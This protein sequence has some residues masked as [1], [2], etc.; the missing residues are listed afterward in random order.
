MPKYL[1]V[2]SQDLKGLRLNMCLAD[3]HSQ[4]SR[5]T[6]PWQESALCPDQGSL[7]CG[8]V[9]WLL[10]RA[11]RVIYYLLKAVGAQQ[12]S[13]N[14]TMDYKCHWQSGNGSNQQNMLF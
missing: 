5:V 12:I 9:W 4:R 8:E 3:R 1:G 6:Q 2:F 7:P 11:N 13:V 10:C 14:K